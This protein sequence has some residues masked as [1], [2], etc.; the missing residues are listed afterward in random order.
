M[1]EFLKFEEVDDGKKR[2]TKLFAVVTKDGK[3]LLG[4]VKWFSRWRRY[5]FFPTCEVVLDAA[6]LQEVIAFIDGQMQARGVWRK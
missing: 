1:S 6:C 4:E 5:A 3:H 2:K